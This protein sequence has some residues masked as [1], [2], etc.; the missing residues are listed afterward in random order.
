VFF[1]AGSSPAKKPPMLSDQKAPCSL[2]GL[3][4]MSSEQ[5]GQAQK[6]IYKGG[7]FSHRPIDYP[8]DKIIISVREGFMSKFF[9]KKDLTKPKI[10]S[11]INIT[12]KSLN[13]T[14]KGA[15]LMNLILS[16]L[17]I[18]SSTAFAQANWSTYVGA[19]GQL[20]TS[21][22]SQVAAQQQNKAQIAA[23]E[24]K[25]SGK[26]ITDNC[27]SCTDATTLS[28]IVKAT[29]GTCTNPA[30]NGW[31]NG[32]G[33]SGTFQSNEHDVDCDN[34]KIC[35][36]NQVVDLTKKDGSKI[37]NTNCTNCCSDMASFIKC[38]PGKTCRGNYITSVKNEILEK[39]AE[40]K[41]L[42][43][44]YASLKNSGSLMLQTLGDLATLASQIGAAMAVPGCSKYC[45][46]DSQGNPYQD[47]DKISCLCQHT[48]TNGVPCIDPTSSECKGTC[49]TQMAGTTLD[50][51]SDEY[52]SVLASCTC[53]K[54]N[55]IDPNGGWHLDNNNNCVN[56]NNNNNNNSDTFNPQYGNDNSGS[57]D[58]T[59]A[60]NNN[61]TPSSTGPGSGAS[62][63]PQLSSSG[64]AGAPLAAGNGNNADKGKPD[65]SSLTG[66]G[67]GRAALATAGTS[68][69]A[70]GGGGGQDFK[71]KKG[72]KPKD[73][74]KADQNIFQLVTA[75]Y[76]NM[77]QANA[78]DTMRPMKKLEKKPEK[79]P[80][81]KQ[82]AKSA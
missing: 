15:G 61:G 53:G 22:G 31:I 47:S 57:P 67:A 74:A 73:I 55:S 35:D 42:C 7:E 49:L 17:F 77:V 9:G 12:A 62:P 60:D 36:Q 34:K 45:D 50:P 82:K 59:A 72:E 79:K 70:G 30:P 33:A 29:Q 65:L 44:S 20:G 64:G 63:S 5:Y 10:F 16:L 71:A 11:I 8:N 51:N 19:A 40:N 43:D 18:I 54:N 6:P 75:I 56:T 26:G 76:T 38:D 21:L 1:L 66:H 14:C 80:V 41:S 48:G 32:E 46:K 68:D 27:A 28:D 37:C 2:F 25:I 69:G 52:K 23:M 78:L 3:P 39:A 24:T 4:R 13:S 81:K 58:T